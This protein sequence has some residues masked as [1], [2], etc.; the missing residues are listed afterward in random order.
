MKLCHGWRLACLAAL[1]V[2]LGPWVEPATAQLL[3]PEIQVNNYTTGYQVDPAVAVDGSGNFV[4]VWYSDGQDGSTYGV[5]GQ[6]FNSVGS[7]LGSEFQVNSYTTSQQWIPAVAADGLG[8]FLVV[9]G[10]LGQDGSDFGVFG[11]RYSSTGNPVGGEFQVNTYTTGSQGFPAVAADGAGNFVVAWMS[12]FQDGSTWGVFGQRFDSAGNP[13]GTEFQANSYT[14]SSQ[15]DPAVAADG[16]GN[17][18]V[19]WE[20]YGQDGSS[21]GVFGQR[22]SSTGSPAGSEFEANTHTTNQQAAPAVAA[23][24]S[25][26]VVVVWASHGGQDGSSAGVFGQRFDSTGS[27]AGSEF[28]VNTYTTNYQ[29]NPAVA[30]DGSGNF[31]VAWD[32]LFEDGSE[33]GVFGTRYNSAGSPVG[34][35]FQVNTFTTGDQIGPAVAADG[36][37]NF[38]VAW[39]SRFQDGSTYGVFGQ[40]LSNWILIDGLEAG[41]ACGWSAAVG[42]GCP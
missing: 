22:F 11:Q 33:R 26:N 38:V 32:S 37:G 16:S 15:W 3:G 13:L 31:V 5:F 4:V 21:D 34:G 9:W 24:A 29:L 25:G 8:N 36:A 19:V 2:P 42:G 20:S 12:E 41:D 7:P 6:R 30:A 39:T 40:R 14:T 23:D 27:P 1:W 28:Q 18:V 17:F 10:S 35:E